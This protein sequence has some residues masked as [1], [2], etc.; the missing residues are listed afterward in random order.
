MRTTTF[1]PYF[2][3]VHKTDGTPLTITSGTSKRYTYKRPDG[4]TFTAPATTK[5]YVLDYFDETVQPEP[6]RR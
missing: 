4:S 5:P 3:P 6:M 2:R 1:I